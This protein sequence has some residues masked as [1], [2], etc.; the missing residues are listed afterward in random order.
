MNVYELAEALASG[1]QDI[2]LLDVRTP[3]ERDIANLEPSLFVPV[4]E[5]P[6]RVDELLPW[7]N[8]ALVVFCH[9]GVRSEYARQWLV[10][11]GF[12]DVH[13]LDGGIDRWSTQIDT[14]VA[15][16]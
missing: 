8:K 7:L 9:H 10:S 3:M 15:R 2:T 16:Y 4:Y 6:E 13:N 11:A 5:L 1:E 14:T 12:T